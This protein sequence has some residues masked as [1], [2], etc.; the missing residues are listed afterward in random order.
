MSKVLYNIKIA[1]DKEIEKFIPRNINPKVLSEA[2]WYFLDAGG[3]RIRPL[4]LILSCQAL[5]GNIVKAIPAAVCLEL[6]H[7][8][9]LIHD[10]IED[11]S[12]R[13]R[14]KL[15]VHKKFGIPHAINVGDYLMI[16]SYKAM[17]SGAKYW[18]VEKTTEILELMSEMLKNT[19]EG[20]GM[21]IEQRNH[22]LSEATFKWYEEMAFKK[23]GYY[24]G[25][26]LCAI[27]ATIAD[28]T[29]EEINALKKFGLGI[30]VVYQII[31]DV[32]DVTM[33]TG[34]DFGADLKEG[35]RTILTIHAFS[36]A[37]KSEKE[38]LRELIGKKDI[39]LNEK[40]EVIA[41][42]K[43]Y[44][45][46]DFAIEYARKLVEISVEEIKKIPET[47]GRERLIKLAKFFVERKI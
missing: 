28:G 41:I 19:L 47:E 1:I 21:E 40:R 26:S 6:A 5:N 29:E 18:G 2:S 36:R 33:D 10:D 11:F 3:K 13:R 9:L 46:I 38:R 31:D 44:G 30:G 32:L 39:T 35:K 43:K 25:G 34:Q 7:S 12:E 42:Y 8:S 23:T 24:T 14:E 16:N 15:T 17:I 45:S 27:G 20:Q 4:L 22:D 37:S